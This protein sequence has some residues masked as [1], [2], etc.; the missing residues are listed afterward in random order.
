LYALSSAPGKAVYNQPMSEDAIRLDLVDFLCSPR[1]AAVL[2]ELRARELDDAATLALLMELR[3]SFTPA[4]AGALLTT[5]RLRRRAGAKFPAAER[6][7][8]TAEALEQA[9]SAVIAAHHAAWID[10]H[11]PPG[12][13]LDLGC[14]IGGDTLALARC[15]PVI[16]YD[17]DPL[18]LRL[19]QANAAACG[20]TGQVDFRCADW[21]ELW[22]QGRLPVAAAAF[23]D[24]ARRVHGRRVFGLNEMQPPLSALL[25]LQHTVPALG[26]KVMPGVEDREIPAGCGVELIGH[27]GACKE[28]VL[29]F[30]P[31]ATQERWASIYQ[32]EAWSVWPVSGKAAPVGPLEP[33]DFL[34][35]PHPALIRAGA[36]AEL[37]DALQ[38]HLFDP[39][40]AYLVT[41]AAVSHPLTQRFVIDAVE[42]YSLKALNR[43]LQRAA[44][45]Q[46]ELKKRGFPVEP[47]SLRSR[48]KL[49]P[50]GAEA[51]IF[52]T[53]RGAERLMIIGRRM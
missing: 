3:Q 32:H 45:G 9:T 42:R 39:Q 50:G 29:W 48:L 13:I 16:A 40:I 14:G 25:A 22:A 1:A 37:C 49:T 8:F 52:F 34:H 33:G 19:A 47:E 27:A 36:L 20:L 10:A 23:A 2:E 31:L 11:A 4:Q 12:P 30:G 6:L 24:P 51:V 44:I 43:W 18:R 53:R 7:F 17:S 15:R 38:A 46:V 26:V 28:A 21:T 41:A 35:E 5:A